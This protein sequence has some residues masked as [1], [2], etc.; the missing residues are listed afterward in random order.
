MFGS[1][2]NIFILGYNMECKPFGRIY[3]KREHKITNSIT[4]EWVDEILK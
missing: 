4:Q 3:S 2:R 1:I